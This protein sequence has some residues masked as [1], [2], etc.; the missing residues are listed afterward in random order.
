[1]YVCMY[2]CMY[3]SACS[4]SDL[5]AGEIFDHSAHEAHLHTVLHAVEGVRVCPPIEAAS[6]REFVCMYVFMYLCMYETAI[7]LSSII[8]KYL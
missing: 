8:Y 5:E 2:V 7:N 3:V 4:D 1:M 6:E